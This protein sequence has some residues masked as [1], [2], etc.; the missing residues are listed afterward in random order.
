MGMQAPE[1][2]YVLCDPLLVF[3]RGAAP[4]QNGAPQWAYGVPAGRACL[5]VKH[6]SYQRARAS[7]QPEQRA[8]AHYGV[9]QVVGIVG[10]GGGPG[11]EKQ[12]GE[13]VPAHEPLPAA[14]QASPAMP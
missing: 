1:E 3:P 8:H 7:Q 13:I 9:G 11:D 6:V 14:A 10:R 12:T 2:M 4:W 5:L